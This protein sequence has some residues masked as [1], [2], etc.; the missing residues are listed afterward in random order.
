[1][2]HYIHYNCFSSKTVTPNYYILKC[3]QRDWQ[4]QRRERRKKKVSF[5]P[6][7]KLLTAELLPFHIN[8][9]YK[10]KSNDLNIQKGP[11]DNSKS[12]QD[13]GKPSLMVVGNSR[14][15]WFKWSLWRHCGQ[16]CKDTSPLLINPGKEQLAS[17]KDMR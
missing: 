12:M 17:G 5:H 1:M 9:S 3:F 4:R 10:K 14:K 7:F 6:H 16:P 2:T 13:G 11:D 8:I 15:L